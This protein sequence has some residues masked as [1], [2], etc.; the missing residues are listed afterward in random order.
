LPSYP[1]SM[2]RAR[3]TAR[4]LL[5]TRT[6]YLR[7]MPC[8]DARTI[9]RISA[10]ATG[11]VRYRMMTAFNAFG[12]SYDE[13]MVPRGGVS[14]FH[15]VNEI[16]S[17]GT[18]ESS[19]GFLR[20][21]APESHQML[22]IGE[23]AEHSPSP[24]N[25]AFGPS[26]KDGSG[27]PTPPLLTGARSG[28]GDQHSVLNEVLMLEVIESLSRVGSNRGSATS[29]TCCSRRWHEFDQTPGECALSEP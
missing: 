14:Q 20:F 12:G 8:P 11:G 17:G 2:P 5:G 27:A 18:Q 4:T 13:R 23:S 16:G 10:R 22:C 28:H 6:A 3:S 26:R 25:R 15:A 9:P 24:C 19:S 1:P 29:L 7:A 21:S